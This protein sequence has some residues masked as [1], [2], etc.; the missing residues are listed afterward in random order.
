MW[1][2]KE[3]DNNEDVW[4]CKVKNNLKNVLREKIH[5]INKLH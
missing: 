1:K 4:Q 5:N 3:V 2:K